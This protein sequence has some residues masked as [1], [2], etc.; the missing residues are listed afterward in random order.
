[1]H[2]HVQVELPLLRRIYDSWSLID[3][4]QNNSKTYDQVLIKC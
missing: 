4:Q 3:C 2:F 1:M